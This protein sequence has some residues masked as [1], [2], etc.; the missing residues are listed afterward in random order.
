MT[1]KANPIASMNEDMA[2]F[3]PGA[4]MLD[5]SDVHPEA[6]GI[7]A[8]QDGYYSMS[9]PQLVTGGETTAAAGAILQRRTGRVTV[10]GHRTSQPTT[11]G[12]EA[13]YAVVDPSGAYSSRLGQDIELYTFMAETSTP[14]IGDSRELRDAYTAMAGKMIELAEAKGVFMA[15]ISVFGQ[16]GPEP[17]EASPNPYVAHTVRSMDERTGFSALDMF[18]VAGF[19]PHTSISNLEAG[20]RAGEAM[21]LLNPILTAPSLTGP[22]LEGGPAAQLSGMT[23]SEQ[24]RKHLEAAGLTPE[25]LQ[26]RYASY[27]YILRCIGSPSAGIWR[28]PAPDSLETYLLRADEKLA[29]GDIN[30]S[31]RLQGWHAD[32]MRAVLDGSGASTFES[33]TYDSFAGNPQAMA[34]NH[35]LLSAVFTALE[36]RAMNGSDVV[37]EVAKA[38]GVEHLD[39]EAR[40]QLAHRTMLGVARY[41]NDAA[42]YGKTPGKWLKETV[43]PLADT[44]PHATLDEAARLRLQANFATIK[45]T[46]PAVR[47]WCVANGTDIPT[48]DTYYDIGVNN[49]SFYM[50]EL[51]GTPPGNRGQAV[52]SVELQVAQTYHARV[53]KLALA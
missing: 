40:L 10:K 46:V 50:R 31:D 37:Q 14:V 17:D 26:R 12:G 21:Q 25:D 22:F 1:E 45:E 4:T 5:G 44:A 39:R 15:P 34:D 24:Q 3:P 49:P 32:R 53:G 28:E 19:Q 38:L 13:E 35:T 9:R 20:L 8:A 30:T 11:Y 7:V 43:L 48:M 36:A 23:F 33:C 41:G 6:G 47:A 18:R 27:R 29:A 42:V 51:A 52:R 16:R 2:V